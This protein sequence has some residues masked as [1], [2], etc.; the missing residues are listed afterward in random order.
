MSMNERPIPTAALEA[1]VLEPINIGSKVHC[2]YSG[3]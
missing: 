2:E 1:P 3:R